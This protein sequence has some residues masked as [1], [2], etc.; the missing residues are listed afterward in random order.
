M[1][2]I[3][4]ALCMFLLALFAL[5]FPVWRRR[6]KIKRWRKTFD[7]DKHLVAFQQLFTTVDGFNLSR[8]ARTGGDRIEYTYGEIDFSSFIALIALT[9]PDINTVFYDFGSGV[10]KAV[11][12][13]AM[14]FNI[15]KSYGI[16]LL[17][18]LH[19][20][21]IKQQLRLKK[22]PGYSKKAKTIQFIN[23]NFLQTDISNATLIFINATAFFGETWDALKTHLNHV[24]IGTIIIT[25]SKKLPSEQ[26][27][28]TYTTIILMS[29][30]PVKA[31]ISKKMY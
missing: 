2:N 11:F 14:V 24:K 20:T 10:G 30:G 27:V 25:T 21:A 31:Y 22:I 13:C 15:R 12:A 19:D 28:V 7:L 1:I 4:I 23:D 5:L 8:A 26:F 3:Y 6:M 18:A 16:E 17:T 9:K 29:W